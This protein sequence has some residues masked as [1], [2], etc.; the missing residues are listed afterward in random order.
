[1]GAYDQAIVAAQR[2]I[3]LATDGGDVVLHALANHYLGFVYQAQGD[4]RRAI[5]CFEQPVASL[6]GAWRR[7]RFGLAILPSVQ[8]RAQLAWCHAEL[9]TFAEGHALG[10]EGL[11]IAK[12][13][14]H[15]GSLMVAYAGIGLLSLCQG[16]LRRAIP[17]LERAMGLCQDADLPVYFPWIAPALGAVYTLAGRVADAIPLLTQALE[18]TIA[19]GV[20]RYQVLSSLSLGA[21]HLLADRLEEAHTLV[22]HTL[23]LAREHQD[24]GH[25][26]YALLLLGEITAQHDPP[27][28]ELAAAHYQQAL[29][30]ADELGMRPLQAHCHRGLGMLY[31][32]TGQREPART[33][34]STAIALYRDMDMT[35]WL[36]QVEASLAQVK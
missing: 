25:Q 32:A 1:M 10:E 33:A 35:F 14:A 6:E 22:E 21:A 8:S 27:Q 31:A 4:Y 36:P 11:Q 28:V 16:D 17:M 24:R 12:A 13:V 3:A 7:E 5:S 15:P 30:L 29:A 20:A 26:A 19:T 2:T 34:L 18:Q 23:V 9:G